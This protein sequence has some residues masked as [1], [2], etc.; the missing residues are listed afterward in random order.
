[1]K[2]FIFSL[3]GDA[4]EWFQSLTPTSIPSLREF[5]ATFN[6]HCQQFFSS[7]LIFYNFCEEYIDCVQGLTISNEICENERYEYGSHDNEGYTSEELME[8]VKYLSA[9][10][11]GLEEDFA[12]HSYEEYAEDTSILET[13][14][15]G[16]PAY[17]EGVMSD[18]DQEQ[19]NFDEYP[20]EDDEKQSD[21]M[22]PDFS[23]FETDLEESHEGEKEESHLLAILVQKFSP[24]NF[25]SINGYPHPVPAISKWDN[26]LP[27]FKGKKHDHP[28]E[29]LLKFHA[30]MLEH[31]FFHEDI[32]IN[33]FYFSLEEDALGWCLS[34]PA[35]SIHSLKY[36]HD[37]F[38]LYY[39]KI[40]STHI[41]FDD[42]C[43]M[44]SLHIL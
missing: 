20:S 38:N 18:T 41:I 36:F 21:S 8:L 39:G 7:K 9:R 24:F 10:M 35:A 17:D 3:D 34:L 11:E 1:M 32:W 42:Y 4:R 25:L 23:D 5:H 40:Y 6:K 30:Y 22:V 12:R 28:D 44:F 2:M 43:K 27:R 16:S 31:G 14:V 26:Y 37:D 29:H 19:T 15:L 13:E 33:M